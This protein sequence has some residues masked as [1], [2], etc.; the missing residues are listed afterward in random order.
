MSAFFVT[1]LRRELSRRVRQAVF[2][3]LG[4]ALGV[5]LV[6]TVSAASAGVKK[7]ET[8][9]LS[10]LYGVATDMTVSGPPP[11]TSQALAQGTAKC[12]R[13]TAR[14]CSVAPGVQCRRQGPD[15]LCG[16]GAPVG[17]AK[18]SAGADEIL[19]PPLNGTVSASTV[20]AVARLHDVTAATGVLTLVYQ[21]PGGTDSVDGVG[22]GH[23]SV[24]PLSAARVVSGHYFTA[25]DSDA[26]VA[27]V[28]SAYAAINNLKVGSAITIRQVRFTVIGVVLQPQGTSPPDVY[29]PLARAQALGSP[30]K[31]DV[32]NLANQVNLIYVAAASAADI[33][34]VQS[35]IS[36]LLP[37]DTVTAAS[38]LASEVTGS[39]STVNKLAND[40]GKWV[41][42][43]ALIAAFAIAC[44]LMMGAVAHRSEE[45]GTL[46]SLGWRTR[47]IVGQVLGESLVIGIVGAAVG[48]GLGFAGAAIITAVAP[49][50]SG[51]LVNSL[52]QASAI[53]SM[54]QVIQN[55]STAPVTWGAVTVPLSLPVTGGVIVLAVVLAMAGGLL[56]GLFG[57][58]R[59]ARLR[60]ADALR[61]VE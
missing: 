18:K 55:G 13:S 12:R 10:G 6:V 4:L 51:T 52:S 43:L 41:S 37:G 5:G 16:G 2:V 11:L 14:V 48:V 22:T 32:G 34:A 44:L 56:A 57:S 30:D 15:L 31:H 45:F 17:S 53:G 29:I 1:Y 54:H 19:F 47:Q 25:P 49:N 38:S 26:D 27:L 46:K 24:G 8:G 58:W 36:R 20:A 35:E 33:P 21:W 9:V 60:P 59:A 42:V 39:L 7:A 23:T 50:V 40:L 61:R 28:D 3:A